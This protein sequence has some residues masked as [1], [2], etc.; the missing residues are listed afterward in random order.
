MSD[1]DSKP[2]Y[3]RPGGTEGGAGLFLIGL[4]MTG[5]GIWRCVDALGVTAARPGWVSTLLGN[6]I[7]LLCLPLL[8]G[9]LLLFR[10]AKSTPG[11]ILL[12]VGLGMVMVDF[13]SRMRV[14]FYMKLTTFVWTLALIPL[15]VVLVMMGVRRDD[16]NQ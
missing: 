15:G 12:W 9:V 6:S 11:W 4:L 10:S 8:L 13:I 1:I 5:T 14:V 2:S 7:V 16:S 3:K